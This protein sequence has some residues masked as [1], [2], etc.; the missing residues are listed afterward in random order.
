VNDDLPTGPRD[1]NFRNRFLWA[2]AFSLAIHEIWAGLWPGSPRPQPPPDVVAQHVR[3]DPPKPTPKPTPRPTPSPKP[4]PT[5]KVTPAPRYTLAP[6]IEVRNPA[7]R[8]AATPALKLG[9]A[10]AHKHVVLKTPPPATP[11][12]APPVSVAEG[13]HAGQQNGG[14]GTGAGAGNGTG[15]QGGSGTGSGTSGTGTGAETNT[16][17]CGDV[18]ILPVHVSTDR[19]GRS[20]QT[21]TVTISL[22][23]G[24]EQSGAFPYPFIY[25][26]ER[27][28]PFLHD[29]RLIGGGVLVQEPPA[30]TDIS[31]LPTTVQVVLA[32]TDPN[33]G[34]TTFPECPPQPKR[35]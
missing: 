2:L 31:Q 33:T 25:R 28:N 27:D 17:P 1:P 24:E 12:P 34:L 18:N 6:K 8:A 9:G 3:F 10:A 20:V 32:H 11:K 13:T 15:G 23:N 30:G 26:S 29:D 7:A 35:K 4:T 19:D 22:R 5:P 21:V 14:T 16:A